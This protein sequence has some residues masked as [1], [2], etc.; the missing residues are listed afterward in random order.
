MYSNIN[1]TQFQYTSSEFSELW[2]YV[3]SSDPNSIR[4]TND[5]VALNK[6]MNLFVQ[7]DFSRDPRVN[8][9]PTLVKLLHLIQLVLHYMSRCQDE[10]KN[11]SE[12][13]SDQILKLKAQDKKYK[14]LFEKYYTLWKRSKR[15]AKCPSCYRL[16]ESMD[17]L[18]GHIKRRHPH[19]LEAWVSIRQNKEC[20][21]Q[22]TTKQMKTQIVKLKQKIKDISKSKEKIT[23]PQSNTTIEPSKLTPFPETHPILKLANSSLSFEIKEEKEDKVP[24]S[25]PKSEKI[26]QTNSDEEK[27]FQVNETKKSD[28]EINKKANNQEIRNRAKEFL[29]RKKGL[30]LAPSEVNDIVGKITSLIHEQSKNLKN[31]DNRTSTEIRD[32]LE[33]EIESTI[34]MSEQIKSGRNNIKTVRE[35]KPFK[36]KKQTVMHSKLVQEEKSFSSALE[37]HGD[38]MPFTSDDHSSMIIS[39]AAE[40]FSYVEDHPDGH[41]RKNSYISSEN[42][43]SSEDEEIVTVPSKPKENS[44]IQNSVTKQKSFESKSSEKTNI[45]MV[46]SDKESANTN[47]SKEEPKHLSVSEHKSSENKDSQKNVFLLN[48]DEYSLLDELLS[49]QDDKVTNQKDKNSFGF[50][51]KSNDMLLF[52]DISSADDSNQVTNAN[53]E[54]KNVQVIKKPTVKLEPNSLDR[55]L[56]ELGI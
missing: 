27:I 6:I 9:N 34:P 53:V 32:D 4:I 15:A 12:Q 14:P 2:N 35:N 25:Y 37:I 44:K 3:Q 52:S 18:D 11:I 20:E 17:H 45:Y 54:K 31:P 50:K 19:F 7:T 26:I 16:F 42:S 28:P 21:V 24:F 1:S 13:K 40:Y 33:G 36:N 23:I 22:D 29:G 48:D 56:A 46:S 10:L 41:Q 55:E 51:P 5:T 30:T 38:S 8:K 49:S 43:V 39:D 47:K